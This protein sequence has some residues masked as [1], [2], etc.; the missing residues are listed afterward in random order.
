MRNFYQKLLAEFP[1]QNYEIK[2]LDDH[3]LSVYSRMMDNFE[4]DTLGLPGGQLI[5]VRFEDLQKNPMKELEK[6]YQALA[7]GD[8]AEDRASYAQYLEG[9]KDY[10]KNVYHFPEEDLKKVEIHWRRFIK[11]G[12]YS[13]P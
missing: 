6:I 11:R 5:E 1:L 4:R 2:N 8:F 13:R 9:V 10:R 3:I 7:L 12:G